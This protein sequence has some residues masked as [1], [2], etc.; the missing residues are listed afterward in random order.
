MDQEHL[1]EIL[2]GRVVIAC[3]GNRMRGDDGVG[4][5]VAG[6]IRETDL[7]RVVDCGE[8]PENFLGTIAR[9][10]PEKVVIVDAAYFGGSPGEIRIVGKEEITGGGASTH[11][12]ILTVFADYIEAETGAQ[13]FFIAIQPSR[14]TIGDSMSEDVAE[15]GKR[16]AAAINEIIGSQG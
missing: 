7:V 12:A 1:T 8:T 5:Y 16:L 13:T 4:P 6:L 10:N 2:S 11:D 9:L 15:A 14:T 3:I